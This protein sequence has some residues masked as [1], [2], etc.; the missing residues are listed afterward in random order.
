MPSTKP[1]QTPPH[2]AKKPRRLLVE[3]FECERRDQVLQLHECMTHYV[4]ANALRD[5]SSP[6]FACPVGLEM[7]TTFAKQG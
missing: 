3:T 2:E 1:G 6:C 4:N 7:R 5:K